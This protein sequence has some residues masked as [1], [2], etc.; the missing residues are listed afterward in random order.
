MRLGL[1]P[2]I[3]E[4]QHGIRALYLKAYR[5]LCMERSTLKEI[6]L[7]KGFNVWYV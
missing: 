1:L 7:S 4:F 2:S 5:I 3:K 6:N